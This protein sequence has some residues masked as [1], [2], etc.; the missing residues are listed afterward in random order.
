MK[1]KLCKKCGRRRRIN[2]FHFHRKT[3]DRLQTWCKDCLEESRKQ[4]RARNPRQKYFSHLR[5]K[6]GISGPEYLA[7]M[8]R[9][10]GKCALCRD[11]LVSR[12]SVDHDH[13]TGR[14]RGI[15]CLNCNTGLGHFKDSPSRLMAAIE[16]LKT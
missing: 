12:H 5:W 16:Y 3:R 7:Q 8:E 10:E 14:V 11:L 4:S 6:Y 1:T 13:A 9:Q 15:L 2:K